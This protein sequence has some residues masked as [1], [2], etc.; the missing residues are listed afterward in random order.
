MGWAGLGPASK[1]FLLEL[2]GPSEFIQSVPQEETGQRDQTKATPLGSRW[3]R[4]E[5]R[6]LDPSLSALPS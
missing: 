6:P 2:E 1:A 3:L 5:L 4:S